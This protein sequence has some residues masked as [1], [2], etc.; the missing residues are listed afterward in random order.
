MCMLSG[1]TQDAEYNNDDQDEQDEEE[2]EDDD[3]ERELMIECGKRMGRWERYE[4]ELRDAEE[5]AELNGDGLSKPGGTL[6]LEQDAVRKKQ[7]FE[8][9]E[10]FL[11]LSREL[12]DMLKQRSFDLFVDTLG[13]DVYSWSVELASF[14]PKSAL[15][16]VC[17][18]THAAKLCIGLLHACTQDDTAGCKS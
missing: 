7:I 13:D 12:T 9:R 8:P 16:K 18:A 4:K 5:A 11:M 2:E 10:A 3:E 17:F 15:Y 1:A 14:D 6:S